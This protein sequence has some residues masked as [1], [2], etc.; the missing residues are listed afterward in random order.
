MISKVRDKTMSWDKKDDGYWWLEYYIVKTRISEMDAY[1]AV[2]LD[3]DAS[4]IFS[5]DIEMNKIL[6]GS[7]SLILISIKDIL[8]SFGLKVKKPESLIALNETEKEILFTL[9]NTDFNSLSVKKQNGKIESLDISKLILNSDGKSIRE[10]IKESGDFAEVITKFEEGR[11]RSATV[12]K[13]KK[14]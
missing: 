11:E 5:R 2:S 12:I 10:Q 14:F 3:G 1:V 4:V 6:L 7:R 8:E 13:K 9:R